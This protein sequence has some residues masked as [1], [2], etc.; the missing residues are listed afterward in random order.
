MYTSRGWLADTPIVGAAVDRL[1]WHSPAAAEAGME[2]VGTASR[3][4][5]PMP[6]AS[7]S[8]PV[9]SPRAEV[10]ID[11]RRQQLIGVRTLRLQNADQRHHSA[12]NDDVERRIWH[13]HKALDVG[14]PEDPPRDRAVLAADELRNEVIQVDAVTPETFSTPPGSVLSGTKRASGQL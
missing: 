9:G 5:D 2:D 10:Q 6:A 14:G 8:A 12:V 1:G 13:R 3:M 4:A 11:P 7:E